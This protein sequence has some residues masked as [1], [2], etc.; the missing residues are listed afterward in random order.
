MVL[1]EDAMTLDSHSQKSNVQR[2]KALV[3]ATGVSIM[4]T[5]TSE[6]FDSVSI[7]GTAFEDF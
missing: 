1:L 3:I 7:V 5:G 2:Q 4:I 6:P